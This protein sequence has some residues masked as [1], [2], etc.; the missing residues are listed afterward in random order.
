MPSMAL[1]N[2]RGRENLRLPSAKKVEQ[3]KTCKPYGAMW[4]HT[5]VVSVVV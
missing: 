5:V 1:G 2:E 3:E 4:L